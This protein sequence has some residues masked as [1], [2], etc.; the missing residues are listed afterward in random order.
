MSVFVTLCTSILK[1]NVVYVFFGPP[2]KCAIAF[3]YLLI[4]SNSNVN[5]PVCC[6][7]TKRPQLNY[8]TTEKE[9]L[10]TLLAL[11]YFEVYFGSGSFPRHC[12]HSSPAACFSEPDVQQ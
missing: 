2:R 5:H 12:V 7:S 6:F 9:T 1:C 4:N 11:Q 10:A 3:I 8:S